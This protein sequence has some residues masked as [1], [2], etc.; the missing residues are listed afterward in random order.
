MLLY[1]VCRH[2]ALEHLASTVCTVHILH[3]VHT[4]GFFFIC[5]LLLFN[6]FSRWYENR[7]DFMQLMYRTVENTFVI[8]VALRRLKLKIQQNCF[9]SS[10][11]INDLNCVNCGSARDWRLSKEE[12]LNTEPKKKTKESKH[13]WDNVTWLHVVNSYF[14]LVVAVVVCSLVI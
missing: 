13:T 6:L 10:Y 7:V 9:H 12:K 2:S 8:I 1:L 4:F 5:D 3:C 11:I 14:A